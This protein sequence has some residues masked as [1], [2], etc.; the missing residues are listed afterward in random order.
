MEGGRGQARIWPYRAVAGEAVVEI[1]GDGSSRE[2]TDG[3]E[4][5]ND[6]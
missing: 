3:P 2:I 5:G 4:S 6:I 1:D